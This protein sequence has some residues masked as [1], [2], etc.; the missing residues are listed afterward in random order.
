MDNEKSAYGMG[1][2]K[3]SLAFAAGYTKFVIDSA[4]GRLGDFRSPAMDE[5]SLRRLVGY[6][7]NELR[8]AA[9]IIEKTDLFS[10]PEIRLEGDDQ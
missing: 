9:N 10:V 1:E 3:P 7:L 6:T 4:I 5:N 8:N 2:M